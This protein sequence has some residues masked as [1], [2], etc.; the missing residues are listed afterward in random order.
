MPF[1]LAHPAAVLPLL[2][3]PFVPVALVAG[4]MAPDAPYFLTAVGIR[5]TRAGD[6]YG[7]F[8]NATTTHSLSGLPI[9]LFYTAVLI[10][11]YWLLRAPI[12]ALG[13]TLPRTRPNILW[14]VA[15]A[16]IGVGTHLLWDFLTDADFL[17]APRLLQYASTAF[18]L[19][20]IA[21]YTWTRRTTLRSPADATHPDFDPRLGPT[22]RRVVIS[23]LVAAPVLTA[24]VLAPGDYNDYAA[25]SDTWTGVAE[26]VL[27]GAV[28]RAG[29]ALV[30]VLL[31]YA[32]ASWTT[33]WIRRSS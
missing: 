4:A 16:V 17:P 29:A 21:W 32:V 14:L 20:A 23:L 28:K 11:A 2:R 25:V 31:V 15:S 33:R 19:L 18:G 30:I 8:L 22:A 13:L 5:S 27:T 3:H 1:T 7:S 6:W 24:A 9:D 26:G 10:A 12:A